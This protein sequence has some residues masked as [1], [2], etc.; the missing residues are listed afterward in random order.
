MKHSQPHRHSH[1][2]HLLY[3]AALA[4]AILIVLAMSPRTVGAQPDICAAP[5]STLSLGLVSAGGR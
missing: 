3:L 5:A 2:K 1:W 4:T